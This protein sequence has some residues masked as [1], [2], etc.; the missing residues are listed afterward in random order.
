MAKRT[1]GRAA[2]RARQPT[3]AG[4]DKVV[5]Q[6]KPKRFDDIVNHSTLTI[7]K[8]DLA[9]LPGLATRERVKIT[10][11]SDHTFDGLIPGNG[12][13]YRF[14]GSKYTSAWINF[15][16]YLDLVFTFNVP[17]STD[18]DGER[19]E[20]HAQASWWYELE[21]YRADPQ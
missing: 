6:A 4:R 12:R 7:A 5:E 10:I 3:T 9:V 21:G 18:S 14:T 2:R 8:K 15:H 13:P 16:A 1:R 19:Q 20:E 17:S 11:V